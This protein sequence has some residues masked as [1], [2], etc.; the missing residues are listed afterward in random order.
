M[1]LAPSLRVFR[2]RAY[3]HFWLMRVSIAAFNTEEEVDQLVAALKSALKY[4]GSGI[5]SAR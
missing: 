3:L 4:F 1:A 5:K 2:H